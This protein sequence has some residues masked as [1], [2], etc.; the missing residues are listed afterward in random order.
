MSE[1]GGRTPLCLGEVDPKGDEGT[2]FS[3][4]YKG[5]GRRPKVGV[6]HQGERVG[7]PSGGAE[8]RRR[9][10]KAGGRP[11]AKRMKFRDM[12]KVWPVSVNDFYVLNHGSSSTL[13]DSPQQ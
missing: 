12:G 1:D 13:D 9:R 11:E 6:N 3:K 7:G 8:P 2:T 10:P 5:N 4:G